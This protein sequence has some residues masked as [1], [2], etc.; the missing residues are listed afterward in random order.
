MI[1]FNQQ[2]QPEQPMCLICERQPR[3]GT[4]DMCEECASLLARASYGHCREYAQWSRTPPDRHRR[5]YSERDGDYASPFQEHAI[6]ILEDVG[7]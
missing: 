4:D 1:E 5:T 2:P 6:R 7:S 3:S